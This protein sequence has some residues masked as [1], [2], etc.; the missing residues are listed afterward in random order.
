[1]SDI[2]FNIIL[3]MLLVSLLFLTG[4]LSTIGVVELINPDRHGLTREVKQE[5][6][7]CE[8]SL[9]LRSSKCYLKVVNPETN[10]EI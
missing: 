5:Y 2:V 7:E 8:K 1:M 10:E 6:K 4:L 3:N 9:T